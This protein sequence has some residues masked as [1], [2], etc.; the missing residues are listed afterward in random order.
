M[1]RFGIL[2]RVGLASHASGLVP[3]AKHSRGQVRVQS[4]RVVLQFAEYQEVQF[5]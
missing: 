2:P 1:A 3:S 5:R 4:E